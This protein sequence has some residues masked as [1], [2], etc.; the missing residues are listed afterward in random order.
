MLWW[1]SRCFGNIPTFHRFILKTKNRPK[2]HKTPKEEKKM[3]ENNYIW[4]IYEKKGR[5]EV[6]LLEF[7]S[8][9]REKQ[10]KIQKKTF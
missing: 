4:W 7:L 9:G 8:L 6:E 10:K 3:T 5:I 1:V 2:K